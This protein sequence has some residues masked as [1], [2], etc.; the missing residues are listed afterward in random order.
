MNFEKTT[1]DDAYQQLEKFLQLSIALVPHQTFALEV[2]GKIPT[3]VHTDERWIHIM[4]LAKANSLLKSM[5][6][7]RA[8]ALVHFG[9]TSGVAHGQDSMRFQVRIE[10]AE[11]RR[12]KRLALIG[13]MLGLC[14]L[15]MFASH[16][17]GTRRDDRLD[18]GEPWPNVG[19]AP[20]FQPRRALPS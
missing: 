18:S 16:K 11:M 7:A 5:T 14:V 10:S 8:G 4:E 3:D 20:P 1:R 13:A 9:T 2:I 19:S 15:V 12:R 6:G 17:R